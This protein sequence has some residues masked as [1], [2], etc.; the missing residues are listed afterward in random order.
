M[1][2]TA[3]YS[4]RSYGDLIDRAKGEEEFRT[5]FN[6]NIILNNYNVLHNIV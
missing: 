1:A 2:G 3:P 6:I 4:E 5:K